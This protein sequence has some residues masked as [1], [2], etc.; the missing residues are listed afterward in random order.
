MRDVCC[1]CA[2]PTTTVMSYDYDE[3]QVYLDDPRNAGQ[4]AVVYSLC[5]THANRMAPPQGW[6]LTDLRRPV[7]ELFADRDVA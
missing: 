3:R 6:V 2:A 1:K 5:E 7:L 4:A